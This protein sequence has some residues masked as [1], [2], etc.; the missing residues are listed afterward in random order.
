MPEP[1]LRDL[2]R[3]ILKLGGDVAAVRQEVA[4]VRAE[5]ACI[6][7]VDAK[8]DELLSSVDHT[9]DTVAALNQITT[10]VR[11]LGVTTHDIS[12]GLS[13]RMKNLVQRLVEKGLI[14]VESLTEDVQLSPTEDAADGRLHVLDDAPRG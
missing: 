12:V 8:V 3:L 11:S 2:E 10:G 9:R 7:M 5:A 14:A 4:S 6:R 1:T 13:R